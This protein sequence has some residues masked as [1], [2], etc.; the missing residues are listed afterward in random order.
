MSQAD[1]AALF[2][3]KQRSSYAV[4]CALVVHLKNLGG[5]VVS[6]GLLF[7]CLNEDCE[8]SFS[9]NAIQAT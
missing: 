8:V 5:S 6:A 7:C 9:L 4:A 3:V 1:I 2:P